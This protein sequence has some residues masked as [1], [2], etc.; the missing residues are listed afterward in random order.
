MPRIHEKIKLIR[1]SG[2]ISRITGY[3]YE[4]R[5]NQTGA[6]PMTKR[7]LK[8]FEFL[9]D[10]SAAIAPFF[11]LA[12]IPVM[13]A[14]GGAMDYSRANNVRSKLQSALD[15]AVL[16]GAR[17]GS[18]DWDQLARNVFETNIKNPSGSLQITASF[19]RDAGQIYRG[20]AVATM[21][22]G[23]LG[24][25]RIPSIDV[26]AKATAIS[27]EADNSCILALDKGQPSTHVALSLNGAPVVDLSGCSIRSNTAMDCN[28]HDGNLTKAIAGGV[29]AGCNRPNSYAATVP[30]IYTQLASNITA[31]C[32]SSRLGVTWTAGELPS[33]PGFK[34]V[35][36]LGRTE[37][38]VCG[39]L[40]LEGAGNLMGV[41]PTSDALIVIENGSLNMSNNASIAVARMG[42]VMTGD[43]N[44]SAQI[45]FPNGNG[46]TAKLALSP[47]IEKD[48]PWQGV[49]LYLDP[50]LTK[51]VD[52]NWGPGAD[53]SADGLVYLG[54]SNVVTDGNTTSNNAKCSKFVMNQ[55]RTN[56]SVRLDFDQSAAS[57]EAI[58]LKQWGGVVVH[59]TH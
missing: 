15:T 43:N 7:F 28:G 26:G 47:P 19:D 35:S 6:A 2:I 58:G 48:N 39:D 14:A 13:T 32:G 56:G 1:G 59:L 40:T 25:V 54:N 20:V 8:F 16:A 21:K 37:Y 10:S 42:I 5:L 41:T 52:N 22:T 46:K 4:T 11:A 29:A 45:N 57:C 38:H 49:A 33:S 53:F 3:H 34:T 9:R 23:L 50:K 24:L 31:E 36:N 27:V 44:S 30:D 12:I 18:S 51:D 55:F 17:D